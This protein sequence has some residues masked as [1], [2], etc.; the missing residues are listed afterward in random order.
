[1]S[2][3][4]TAPGTMLTSLIARAKQSANSFMR[5]SISRCCAGVTSELI[6]ISASIFSTQSG[7]NGSVCRV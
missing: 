2:S 4:C 6:W 1:M 5:S 7:L 3:L